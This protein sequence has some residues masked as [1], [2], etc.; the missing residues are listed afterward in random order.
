MLDL[1]RITMV[2]Q[3]VVDLATGRV[4]GYEAL[5]RYP[6]LNP[7]ELFDRAAALGPATVEA[8][9]LA[10]ARAACSGARPW[11]PDG[12]GVR[13]FVNLSPGTLASIVAGRRVDLAECGASGVVVWELSERDGWPSD[14]Q[15]VAAIRS[16]LRTVAI[17][18]LGEGWSETVRLYRLRPE[19]VKLSM[20][21]V[22]GCHAE[23]AQA[24]LLRSLVSLAT[25]IGAKV[26]AEGIESEEE[27][28]VVRA[29]GVGF[30]QGYLFAVPSVRPPLELPEPI[31][32]MLVGPG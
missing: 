14:S 17:D 30:G 20:T 6:E 11:L 29:C 5:A 15:A 4:A 7:R 9:D 8:L 32:D 2:Y 16:Q 19:W 10:C 22:R 3:P 1:T 25:E 23:P 28:A 21:V 24:A 26:V 18:D 13:L 27:L 31:Q 12:G